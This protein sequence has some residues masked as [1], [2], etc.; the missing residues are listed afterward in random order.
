[1]TKSNFPIDDI[2]RSRRTSMLVDKDRP[3]SEELIHELCEIAT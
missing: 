2:I 1:M 3:V